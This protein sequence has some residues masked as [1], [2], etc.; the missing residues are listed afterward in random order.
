VAHSEGA[1]WPGDS[2]GAADE[3]RSPEIDGDRSEEGRLD[4]GVA[5]LPVLE[6]VA[7]ETESSPAETPDT[8][9]PSG[10]DC[11]RDGDGRRRQMRS[12]TRK[13]RKRE[14]A[15]AW[16]KRGESER[17]GPGG[18][19]EAYPYPPASVGAAVSP[20]RRRSPARPCA[21]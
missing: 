2:L 11:R 1:R 17:G 13:Q 19:N 3:L 21:C 18:R 5:G 7:Q 20:F 15:W 16:E 4:P 10:D 12:G 8:S 14:S 6:A 9:E